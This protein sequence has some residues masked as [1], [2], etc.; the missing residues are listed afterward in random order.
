MMPAPSTDPLQAKIL[1]LMPVIFTVSFLWA[2][3]GMVLYWLVSNLMGILQ[4]SVTLKIIGKPTHR[5]PA[6]KGRPVKSVGSASTI[7]T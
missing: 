2:P 4:Q 5:M 6:P 3:S 1:L 7:K